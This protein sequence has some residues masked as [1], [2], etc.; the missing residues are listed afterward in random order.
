[1]RRGLV[2]TRVFHRGHLS[3]RRQ[4]GLDARTRYEPDRATC[5]PGEPLEAPVE[6]NILADPHLLIVPSDLFEETPAA[7]LRCALDHPSEA[8]EDPPGAQV[9]S[10][11]EAFRAVN[12]VHAA[13]DAVRVAHSR[14]DLLEEV[15]RHGNVR[16]DE[17]EHVSLR[18]ACPRVPG[19]RDSLHRL[20]DHS[21]A[22]PSGDGRRLVPAV[23][24]YDD[25]VDVDVR[26]GTQLCG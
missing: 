1:M 24:V 8:G 25:R 17:D 26:A 10:D 14:V 15:V 5:S 3:K 12:D 18:M 22:P 16:V 2:Q 19:S 4:E 21:R 23:V 11:G 13:S 6:V 7:E 9:E 20:V